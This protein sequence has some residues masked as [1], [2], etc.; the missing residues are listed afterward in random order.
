MQLPH[1]HFQ[2]GGFVNIRQTGVHVQQLGTGFGLGYG[3]GAGIGAVALPQGLLQALF[4][5]GVD[6]LAHHGN[7]VYPTQRT[8]V[9]RRLRTIG[10]LAA[11][12]LSWVSSFSRRMDSGSEPQQPPSMEIPV[13]R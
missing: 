2:R 4:A 5:G 7:A 6:A 3:L 13:G 9:H 8:G 1:Q 12:V 10:V 11:G